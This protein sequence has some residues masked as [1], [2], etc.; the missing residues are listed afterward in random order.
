MYFVDA[1][2]WTGPVN[3]VF[4]FRHVGYLCIQI[5]F[6]FRQ[7]TIV[8]PKPVVVFKDS[9]I[10]AI[11]TLRGLIESQNYLA[12]LWWVQFQPHVVHL[13]DQVMV[14]KQLA[15]RTDVDASRRLQG[16]QHSTGAVKVRIV[17]CIIIIPNCRSIP[18]CHLLVDLSIGCRVVT[19][20]V[21]GF[22]LKCITH[23]FN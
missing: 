9:F 7:D 19:N 20:T 2:F 8:E 23:S 17:Y 12:R 1:D 11:Q 10:A 21:I 22:P 13:A 4:T 5:V 18:N 3:T 14:H 16:C 15:S 6:S